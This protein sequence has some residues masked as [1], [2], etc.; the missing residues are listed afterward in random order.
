[1]VKL[2]VSHLLCR[3]CFSTPML[4]GKMYYQ[5]RYTCERFQT[6]GAWKKRLATGR[7]SGNMW[8]MRRH[9]M[10]VEGAHGEENGGTEFALNKS[11]HSGRRDTGRRLRAY[12][13]IGLLK[14]TG[15]NRQQMALQSRS[16]GKTTETQRTNEQV[17]MDFVNV[18]GKADRR[19]K[20]WRIAVAVCMLTNAAKVDQVCV[21]FSAAVLH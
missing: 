4:R 17:G 18:L 8:L 7:G 6:K 5:C 9:R 20:Y 13:G 12:I 21:C 16:V 11:C 10:L 2:F 19:V 14:R 3:Q 15:V 1:M